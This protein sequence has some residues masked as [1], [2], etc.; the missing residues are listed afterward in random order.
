MLK[1]LKYG[2]PPPAGASGVGPH[3]HAAADEPNIRESYFPM[4]QQ[5][6]I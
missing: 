6:V 2:A 3:R 4:N 5:G 1:R